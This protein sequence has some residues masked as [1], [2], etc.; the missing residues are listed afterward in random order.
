MGVPSS[1][2]THI[3]RLGTPIQ[4]ER[5][6]A[7]LGLLHASIEPALIRLRG[8]CAAAAKS[9][10]GAH[11]S[12]KHMRIDHAPSYYRVIH[13]PLYSPKGSC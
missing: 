4:I 8:I 10:S 2:Q 7:F 9:I 5:L 11:G 6:L 3:C 12:K 1:R 13:Q